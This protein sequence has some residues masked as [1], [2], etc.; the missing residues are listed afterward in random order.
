LSAWWIKLGI[1]VEFIASGRPCENGAH[2][3]FVRD[4]VGLKPLGS[5]KWNVYFGK[6]LI[7]HL[8]ESEHGSIRMATYRR[9][10]HKR[11]PG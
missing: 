8:R 7:G 4:Y 10:R 3:A 6:L 1:Q 11:A 2:E 9:P 5:G